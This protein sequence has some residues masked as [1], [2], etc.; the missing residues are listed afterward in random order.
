MSKILNVLKMMM[1]K[2]NEVIWTWRDF[3]SSQF[4]CFLFILRI[5][6]PGARGLDSRI[7]VLSISLKCNDVY[8]SKINE[9][10]RELFFTDTIDSC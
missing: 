2:T 1:A 10:S 9:F 3:S 7:G 5:C 6:F 8:C 4:L